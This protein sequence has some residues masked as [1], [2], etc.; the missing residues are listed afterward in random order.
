VFAALRHERP[1]RVPLFYRD[2]PEVETILLRHLNLSGR[3]ELLDFFDI[4]FRWAAPEYIGP[5][6]AD[7]EKGTTRD[8]WGVEYRYIRFDG[9]NGYWE[10]AGHPLIECETPADLERHC[11]PKLEWFDFSGL[12]E[13]ASRYREYAVM[14]APGYASPGILL[15]IQ[16]LMGEQKA[17][18]DILGNVPLFEAAV[19]KVLE[20][21]VPFT[22]ALLT[23]ADGAID[24]FRIG[25]DYGGQHGLLFSPETWRARLKPGLSV[26]SEI[27]HRHGAWYYQHSCGSIARLIPD[28]IEIGVDV[29]DPVQ[30]RAAG[31]EPPAL[32][33]RFGSEICFSGGVDEQVLLRD[34]SVDDVRAGVR[35]LIDAMGADGGF[36]IGPTHNF[37]VDIPPENIVAMYEEAAAYGARH[38]G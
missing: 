15:P 20:F 38:D 7:R 3:D 11:W 25:D 14:T 8:I 12:K 32:K 10:P 37:Q 16:N 33:A 2:V 13:Q 1:D 21:L 29:V 17:W 28:F 23:A 9:T 5:P 30:V 4:D 24:F 35:K 22:D 31:M 18:T 6:L 27:V 26:L 36:F 19:D 34:G